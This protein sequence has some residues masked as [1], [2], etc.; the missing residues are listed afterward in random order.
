M[1]FLCSLL[2]A[3][4]DICAY[5]RRLIVLHPGCKVEQAGQQ[6]V[7]EGHHHGES[8]QAGLS[9]QEV[10]VGN[11]RTLLEFLLGTENK[12]LG[13]VLYNIT[14]GCN[15]IFQLSEMTYLTVYIFRG[16]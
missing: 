5:R 7:D 3:N 10:I 9:Q 13:D 15:V 4:G 12:E 8:Q 2:P 14:V 16:A 11:T 6:Q 1:L